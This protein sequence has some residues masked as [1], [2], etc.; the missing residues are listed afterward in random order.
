MSNPQFEFSNLLHLWAERE[1]VVLECGVEIPAIA[2]LSFAQHLDRLKHPDRLIRVVDPPRLV[3]DWK[4]CVVRS[5]TE[6]CNQLG[7]APEGSLFRVIGVDGHKRLRTYPC[8]ECGFSL[9]IAFDGA[10]DRFET[11]FDFVEVT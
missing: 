6:L 1:G 3:R 2:M 5:R 9:I 4:D 10:R 8:D 7:C 11:L